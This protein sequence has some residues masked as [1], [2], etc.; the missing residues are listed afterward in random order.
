MEEER[1]EGVSWSEEGVAGGRGEK[2]TCTKEELV[3][4]TLRRRKAW[5]SSPGSPFVIVFY[6]SSAM[7]LL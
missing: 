2:S 4:S 7:K 5:V 6:F 3:D 1:D